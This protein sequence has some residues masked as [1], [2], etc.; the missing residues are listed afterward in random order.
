LTITDYSDKILTDTTLTLKKDE[1]LIILGS[2]GAGKSTLA[3]LLCGVSHSKRVEIDGQK[4]NR[5]SAKERS[6]NINYIPPKLEIFDEYITVR[7]FLELSR[8]YGHISVD[9]TIRLLDLDSLANFS[10]KTLSS[11]E[12]QRLLLA[13]SLLHGA[14]ITIYDEPTAN[15]DPN[16][17]V[18]VYKILQ[19]DKIKSRIIITHD[20]SLAYRLEYRVIYMDKGRIVFDDESKKFF[21]ESNLAKFFGDSLKRVDDYFVVNI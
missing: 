2:N 14:E 19:S 13:S 21:E 9:E 12:Q 3:K 1:N 8:L 6:R 18:E 20:L 7:D 11:G 10:C 17:T 5:L 15:L 16:R 4:F